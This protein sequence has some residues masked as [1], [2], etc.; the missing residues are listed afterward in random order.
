MF[1]V[2]SCQTHFSAAAVRSPRKVDHDQRHP[3]SRTYGV[4]LP[5]S[6][7]TVLSRA[8][9]YSPCLPVSVLVRS[10]LTYA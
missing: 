3:L 8:L 2:N 1:L 5:S 9:G 7:P 10:P 6:F 4:N